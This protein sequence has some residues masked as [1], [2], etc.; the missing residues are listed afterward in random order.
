[1]TTPAEDE[2]MDKLIKRADSYLECS[3][4]ANKSYDLVTDLLTELTAARAE[5][6][7]LYEKLDALLQHCHEAEDGPAG[8]CWK[9]SEIICPMKDPMHFHHDGCPSCPIDAALNP[10]RPR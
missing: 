8:E 9:C 3:C 5:I 10:R 6:E 2:R 1:M 7:G 4:P